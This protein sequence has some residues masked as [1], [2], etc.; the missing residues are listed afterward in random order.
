MEW[1]KLFKKAKEHTCVRCKDINWSEKNK[2]CNK[3]VQYFH[4][5]PNCWWDYENNIEIER[6]RDYWP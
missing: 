4:N 5:R 1:D 3:C 6:I 2:L